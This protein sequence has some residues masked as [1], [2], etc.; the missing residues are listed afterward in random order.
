MK[1]FLLIFAAAQAS[2]AA[3]MEPSHVCSTDGFSLPEEM[4]CRLG[5]YSFCL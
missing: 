1:L 2:I 5:G 4:Y 3:Q